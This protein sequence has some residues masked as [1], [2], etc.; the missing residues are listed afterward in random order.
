[1]ARSIL[2]DSC[3]QF[4]SLQSQARGSG[5]RGIRIE[6]VLREFGCCAPAFAVA[7]EFLRWWFVVLAPVCDVTFQGCESDFVD[8]GCAGCAR[9]F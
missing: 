3:F 1:M 5:S 9:G 8:A 4:V 7:G 2:N 6:L